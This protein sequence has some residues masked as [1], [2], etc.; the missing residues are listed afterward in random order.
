MFCYFCVGND[1]TNLRYREFGVIFHDFF[2]NGFL[3]ASLG[4]HTVAGLRSTWSW[5]IFSETRKCVRETKSVRRN[6]QGKTK[7]ET[8]PAPSYIGFGQSQHRD[9]KSLLS[10]ERA[11]WI[12]NLIFATKI[13]ESLEIDK[14]GGDHF[15][16]VCIHRVNCFFYICHR[17]LF[18]SIHA[19]VRIFLLHFSFAT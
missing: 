8:Q 10:T 17:Q 7:S 14:S 16:R 9:T 11:A 18:L 4:S 13:W 12:A 15:E 5:L 6:C 1:K 2:P 3:V 19:G